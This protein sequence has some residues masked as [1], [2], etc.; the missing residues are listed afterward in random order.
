MQVSNITFNN[1]VSTVAALSQAI[2][3][4]EP[5]DQLVVN[6]VVVVQV[7]ETL[8]SMALIEN[9]LTVEEQQEV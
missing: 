7:F 1:S 2:N 3:E 9:P 4:T 6:F 5:A 8:A